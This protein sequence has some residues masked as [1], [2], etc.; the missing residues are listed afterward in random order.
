MKGYK[1]PFQLG[2][3]SLPNNIFIAPMAGCTD[4]P[5]RQIVAQ[6][7]P[8]LMFCEMVKIE[9]LVR[10][11]HHTLQYLEYDKNIRP[12]GAQI[13]GSNPIIVADAAKMIEDL[14]F[15]LLDINCG[16]PVPKVTKDGSGSAMLLHPELIEE[17]LYKVIDAVK[18]PVTIKIRMGWDKENII[19][20]KIVEIAER[21]GA[22]AIT[23]HGRT[24]NQ[25][26]KG[27]ANWEIIR[28][29]K[30]RAK[31]IKI[32]GNG[33]IWSAKDACDMFALTG[34]DGVMLARGAL[35]KPW[36]VQEIE[37]MSLEGTSLSQRENSIFLELKKHF[38]LILK[39]TQQERKI[40]FDMRRVGCWYLKSFEGAKSL[41]A[42]I[43]TAASP[44]EVMS[45]LEDFEKINIKE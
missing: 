6:Y 4:I 29:C 26:Y 41:R 39:S 1:K 16:C 5:Y 28:L 22:V 21:A 34:C 24:R 27:K 33:D 31:T 23:I 40:L 7:R 17:I 35:G 36:L 2:P 10:K 42:A 25:R 20:E 19:A 43:N 38:E 15:D 37:E 3:L 13:C 44:S 32:I 12:I 14:G 11:D 18:I 9:A 45:I 8:G 30:Q